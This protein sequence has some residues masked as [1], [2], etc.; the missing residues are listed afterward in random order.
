MAVDSGL[1]KA[2]TDRLGRQPDPAW[3]EQAAMEAFAYIRLI[4]P[5]RK[6]EWLDWH[7][8]PDGVGAILVAA[9]ARTADNPRGYRQETI[10]EYSY[11][12]GPSGG[13]ATGIFSPGEARVIAS[14]GGCGGSLKTVQMTTSY[15]VTPA[16]LTDGADDLVIVDVD[17]VKPLSWQWEEPS[18]SNGFNGRWVG[19]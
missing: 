7:S 10:G 17:G 3:L 19:A 8:I 18:H 2:V 14:E 11:T 1:L 4:A 6:S 13:G 15:P 16:A 9:L 12:L 5:C